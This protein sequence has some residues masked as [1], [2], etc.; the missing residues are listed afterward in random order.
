V[1][2]AH[3]YLILATELDTAA[4]PIKSNYSLLER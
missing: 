4:Q 2:T 3:P 1:C